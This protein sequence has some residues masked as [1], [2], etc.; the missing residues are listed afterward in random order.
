MS[1]Q[2]TDET[3]NRYFVERLIRRSML[4]DIF[5]YFYEY[6]DPSNSSSLFLDPFRGDDKTRDDG[7]T[8]MLTLV[9]PRMGL[10]RPRGIVTSLDCTVG[11]VFFGNWGKYDETMRSSIE[12]FPRAG[13]SY[14][15]VRTH[16]SF[17]SRSSEPLVSRG[18]KNILAP[19]GNENSQKEIIVVYKN[20]YCLT[21]SFTRMSIF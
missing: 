15:S 1:E 2:E 12:M 8:R 18:L 17:L 5:V 9:A 7:T 14:G 20:G 3:E 19:S 4:L 21:F 6:H 13:S 16:A 10:L 11:T